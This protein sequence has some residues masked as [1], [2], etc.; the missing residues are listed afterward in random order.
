MIDNQEAT[1]EKVTLKVEGMTCGGCV[2]SVTR[3]LKAVSGVNDVAVTLIPGAALVEFDPA[4]T[5]LPALQAA[6]EGAGFDVVA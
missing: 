6:V 5:G 2:A 1:M 3:V 4:Q